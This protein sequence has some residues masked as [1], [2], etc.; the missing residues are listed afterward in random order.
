MKHC[1][2]IILFLSLCPIAYS[3]NGIYMLTEKHDGVVSTAPTFDSVFVTDPA[4]VTTIYTITNFVS[5]PSSHNSQFNIILNGI[6]SLG[7][8]IFTP[9]ETQG[10][11][12]PSLGQPNFVINTI[13]LA[14]SWITSI[15]EISKAEESKILINTYPN[16]TF[17]LLKL[18]VFCSKGFEPNEVV[19]INQLGFIVF[20]IPINYV[21]NS[22][23]NLDVSSLKAGTYLLSVRNKN[24]YSNPC[25]L[26]IQ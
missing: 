6:T 18:E 15:Q 21:E 13:Y 14:K 12:N 9:I 11:V 17:G 25:K 7:Y 22:I 24:Y 8:K 23:I 10:I 20:S 1:L 5:N 19:I 3:Q 26:I 2:Q 4:G 16:P